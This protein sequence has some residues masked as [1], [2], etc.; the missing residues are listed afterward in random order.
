MGINHNIFIASGRIFGTC[1]ECNGIVRLDKPVFGSLHLC[2]GD[3]WSQV[4][5]ATRDALLKSL[6]NCSKSAERDFHIARLGAM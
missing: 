1:A 4:A 5:R 6:S 3:E 2:P